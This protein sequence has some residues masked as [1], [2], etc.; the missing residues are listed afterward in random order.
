MTNT[1]QALWIGSELSNIEL[2][3]INSFIKN[4]HVY[5]LYCY[6][7]IKNIP[8]GVIVKDGNEI[9]DKSEIFTYKNGS[10]SAFSN[11]FRFTLLY[12]Q[13]GYWADTDLICVKT[14][15]DF[16]KEDVVIISEP[17]Q[18]YLKDIPTS[19]FIKLPKNSEIAKRAIEI[20]YEHKKLIL[21]GSMEWSSG[22]KT[23][24]QLVNEF[25]LNVKSWK[26]VCTCAW[27]HWISLLDS[28]VTINKDVTKKIENIPVETYCIHL[29]HEGLR[30]FFIQ[31][32]MTK[33]S[34]FKVGCLFEELK[35]KYLDNY[36][37]V[38]TEESNKDIKVLQNN[39]S[40]Y[41]SKLDTYSHNNTKSQK[42]SDSVVLTF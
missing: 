37:S 32:Q 19:C 27:N 10:Y 4:G 25:N 30:K 2:L 26:T 36:D 39:I 8:D 16:D 38:H 41:K 9:L 21:D 40:S 17:D 5:H 34:R 20:Q 11:L 31:Y 24:G 23:V 6:D 18:S 13:G 33:N 22:P 14:L 15:K 1:I 12:K 28:N 42:L 29:W 7:K 35:K 3:S